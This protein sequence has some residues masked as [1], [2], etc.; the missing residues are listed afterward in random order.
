MLSQ[1]DPAIQ[2]HTDKPPTTPLNDLRSRA[3]GKYHK[4]SRQ[5]GLLTG[6]NAKYLDA[7]YDSYFVPGAM[8][9]DEDEYKLVDGVW[10]KS[11]GVFISREWD[12]VSQELRDCRDAVDAVPDPNDKAR[13]VRRIRGDPKSGVP[14]KWKEEKWAMRKWMINA[15][16]LALHPDWETSRLVLGNGAAWGEPE[17][18]VHTGSLGGNKRRRGNHGGAI[19]VAGPGPA[20]EKA[21]QARRTLQEAQQHAHEVRGGGDLESL[22]MNLD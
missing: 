17:V 18:V 11:A 9:D 2:V 21:L 22:T 20:T 7:K 13:A 12:F 5:R 15:D 6:V 16:V 3:T 14:R 1:H 4:R 10:V 19:A 8:S